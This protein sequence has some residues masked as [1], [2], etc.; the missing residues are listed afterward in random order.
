MHDLI[1]LP[2]GALPGLSNADL[3]RRYQEAR[4]IRQHTRAASTRATYAKDFEQF[5]LWCRESGH[6]F[7]PLPAEP[8][9]V[10]MHLTDCT[11]GWRVGKH[12]GK[13]SVSSISRRVA[14]ITWAHKEQGL[15][16][17]CNAQVKEQ[18]SAIRRLHRRPVQRK[19][20]AT[21]DRIRLMLDACPETLLGKRDRALLA[22]G[23]AGAF[24]RS[25]LV[26]LRVEDLVRVD[27]GLRITIRRSKTDQTGQGQEIVVP[28]GSSLLPVRA[29]EEW[30][31]SAGITEGLLLRAV[32]RGGHLKPGGLRGHDVARVVKVYA[33]KVGLDATEFS[34]HSLRAGFATSAAETGALVLKI[35][36]T[37]RHRSVDVLAAYVRRVDLFR[38]HAGAKFL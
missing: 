9:V 26:A 5:V 25:E 6:D 27:E 17:P 7:T 12:S 10:I 2:E 34:G 23:F 36:E 1:P 38:D 29:V 4:E 13:L 37:T 32:H 22:L 19:A 8:A 14:A 33:A 28:H 20:A 18:V 24:R 35:M 30:I 11:K 31:A 21:A 15:A 3:A 16:D